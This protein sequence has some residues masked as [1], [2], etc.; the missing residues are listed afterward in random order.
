MPSGPTTQTLVPLVVTS[1]TPVVTTSCGTSCQLRPPSVVRATV[2][3]LSTTQPCFLSLN[4]TAE[5]A[6]DEE[7]PR[8]RGSQC[9]PPS[10][11][12]RRVPPS[13][14]AH[15]CVASTQ[16]TSFRGEAVGISCGFQ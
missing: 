3:F 1:S 11:V 7:P 10:V 5:N 9:A 13:P 8:Y 2:P 15:T 12:Y 6:Y 16:A 4:A 14:T